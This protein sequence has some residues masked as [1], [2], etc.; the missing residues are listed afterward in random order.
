MEFMTSLCLTRRS[1]LGLGAAALLSPLAA[2]RAAA[3]VNPVVVELFTSQGCSSCPPA[4]AFMGELVGQES[5]IGLSLNVDYWDYIGWRDTLASPAHTKRQ[6]DYARK[7]GDNRIYTPQMVIN[8]RL[9][10]VGSDRK[11][12]LRMIGEEARRTEHVSISV[13]GM[14]VEIAVSVG[15]AESPSLRKESTILLMT[16]L[17]VVTVAIEKGENTGKQVSYYNVVRKIMPLG[18]WQGYPATVKLP[19]ESLLSDP[20]EC[21]VGLLQVSSTGHIIA[22]APWGFKSRQS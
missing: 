12:V 14:G 16:L 3:G 19:K 7:R 1:T 4:D 20:Q 15:A 5:V 8:G 2:T 18:M 6:R 22:A 9:H 10:A 17:P 11:T 21:I 13:D